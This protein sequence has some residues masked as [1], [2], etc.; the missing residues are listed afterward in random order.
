MTYSK[1]TTI[2]A[3]FSLL[4]ALTVMGNSTAIEKKSVSIMV[5]NPIEIP[6]GKE[7][8]A[9]AIWD[10]YAAYFR[11]QPGYI[12][13]KLHRSVDPKAKFHLINV[14]EWESGE[15]FMKA[16]TSDEI[17]KI[18][19]GFPKDMPHYPSMYQIIRN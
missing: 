8:Q 18:G 6:K 11:K 7:A 1:M 17:K 2:T 15:A 14:A 16:L 5:I 3:L 10:T 12:G 4:L 9:L 19:E 13:T